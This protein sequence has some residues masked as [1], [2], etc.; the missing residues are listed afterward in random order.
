MAIVNVLSINFI[1]N[2][3]HVL[4]SIILLQ[5]MDYYAIIYGVITLESKYT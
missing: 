5:F 1:L 4:K 3:F 2:Y